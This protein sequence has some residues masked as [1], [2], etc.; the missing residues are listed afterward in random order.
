MTTPSP[1]M[2]PEAYVKAGGGCCPVC[3]S[4]QTAGESFD[5]EAAQ[6][7]QRVCCLDGEAVWTE[8]YSLQGYED[9]ERPAQVP[10]EEQAHLVRAV[11][12][13]CDLKPDGV[14]DLAAGVGVALLAL[15]AIQ[16]H[17]QVALA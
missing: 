1:L 13:N 17:I 5:V 4:G 9:L 6:V 2:T 14:L 11:L 10:E 16:A 15:P 12:R 7:W 3:R 8:V